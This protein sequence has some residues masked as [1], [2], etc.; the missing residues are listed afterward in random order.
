MKN[1]IFKRT[2]STNNKVFDLLYV[3]I[4]VIYLILMNAHG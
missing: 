4:I 1:Y 2:F 3:L